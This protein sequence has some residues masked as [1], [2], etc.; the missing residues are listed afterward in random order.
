MPVHGSA[1]AAPPG[2]SGTVTWQSADGQQRGDGGARVLAFPVSR[3]A[4]PPLHVAGFRAG[5]VPTDRERA[6]A[7][8]RAAGGDSVIAN[9]SGRYSL[10]LAAGRYDVLFVSRHQS[11]DSAQPLEAEV[12]ALLAAWFDQPAGLVGSVGVSLVPAE[13]D[14]SSLRLDHGFEK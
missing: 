11:R 10:Q 4:S 8:I 6:M 14:G 13:F 3:P 9:D 7:E 5:T 2:L 12:S 1:P